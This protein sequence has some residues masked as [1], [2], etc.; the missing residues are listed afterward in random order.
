MLRRLLTLAACLLPGCRA[1]P[2]ADDTATQLAEQARW[3][4]RLVVLSAPMTDDDVLL[5]QRTRLEDIRTE[6]VER[7][8]LVIQLTPTEASFGDTSITDAGVDSLRARWSIP[9]DRFQAA[10]VGKDGRVKKRWPDAFDPEDMNA[11]I[12]SMPMRQDEM[13]TD[14]Q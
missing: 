5:R 2:T 1:A 12:D 6:L 14:R 9:S 8:L 7:H 3:S 4:N 11:L 10:L 13:Q